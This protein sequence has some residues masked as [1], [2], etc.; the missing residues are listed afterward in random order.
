MG[1]CLN[2]LLSCIIT[3]M[4]ILAIETS[5]DETSASV[6]ED[7]QILHSLVINSQID[8]HKAYG[9][10]VPE[11]AARSHVEVIIPVIEQAL[12][13]AGTD[14]P[15]INA[16]AVTRGPGLLGSLLVGVL[17]AKTVAFVKKIPLIPVHHILGHVYAN[18]ITDNRSNFVF[19]LP[20]VQPSFPA[21]ALIVSGGHSQLM[22]ATNHRDWQVVGRTQDDAVGEAFDKVAKILELPYPGGPSVAEAAK[23]GNPDRY[24]LPTP[25]VVGKYDFSFSGLKTAVLR[26]V[27]KECGVGYDFPS[28]KLSER[29]SETQKA[30][31][32]AS[33]QKT[34]VN[35]LVSKTKLAVDSLSPK[36]LI[37]GGGVAASLPLREALKNQIDMPLQYAPQ[38]LCTDN[39][40]MIAARAFF[41]NQFEKPIDPLTLEA[42]SSWPL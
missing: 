25:K 8:L 33:F 30:D 36:S 9:G 27:Q 10:V 42:R 19:T 24:K 26:A 39:A 7:G 14:W 29:L 21:L 18:F 41:Q 6:V 23:N 13:D 34:A 15:D 3:E 11:I 17:A 37:I 35:Y 28:L 2:H 31:F 4:K 16:I 22:Y 40:A 5:C 12:E 38:I 1:K 32:A 20:N